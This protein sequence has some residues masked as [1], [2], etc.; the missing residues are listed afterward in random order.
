MAFKVKIQK[1]GKKGDFSSEAALGMWLFGLVK[2]MFPE[3][4]KT[5]LHV[6]NERK[7]EAYKGA[8]L[9]SQGVR[10]GVCDYLWLKYRAGIE[11]KMK[12]KPMS[13]H[14]AA[15]ASACAAFDWP[16][17]LVDDKE[18]AYK[19]LHEITGRPL[20][21]L[22]EYESRKEA[23]RY[24]GGESEGINETCAQCGGNWPGCGCEI[25]F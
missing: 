2:F 24:W 20:A 6:P 16:V 9:K 3:D 17:Y 5:F 23:A 13:K 8:F 10:A 25:P 12:D 19:A 4:E 7:T 11:I 15:F 22:R 14:Q 18:S 1:I 21:D